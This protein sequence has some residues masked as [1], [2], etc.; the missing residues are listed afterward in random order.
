M[1]VLLIQDGFGETLYSFLYYLFW[2]GVPLVA[3]IGLGYWIYH[4]FK[5]RDSNNLN[6]RE[7][8]RSSGNHPNSSP[9]GRQPSNKPQID[10]LRERLNRLE[11]DV[12]DIRLRIGLGE[13]R[14][15]GQDPYGQSKSSSLQSESFEPSPLEPRDLKNTGFGVNDYDSQLSYESPVK[16]FCRLY[17][18]A[19]DD[20]SLRAEFRDRYR[21]QRIGT[22]NAMQRR[23]NPSLSP[24]FQTS[25]DGDYFAVAELVPAQRGF[26]VVPRF[27]LTFQDTNY[28]PGAMGI[29]FDCPNYDEG[30]SYRSVKVVQ[31][32][33]FEPDAGTGWKVARKGILSLGVGE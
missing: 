23:R 8:G 15:S 1:T 30:L 6:G 4:F 19:V 27:D 25:N 11:Q 16:A 13:L 31:P 3:V 32:A 21:P 17:N 28:G 14:R 2:I 9:H 24:E 10:D 33:I 5:E 7:R 26:A 20:P 12:R 18:D 29:V 22:V